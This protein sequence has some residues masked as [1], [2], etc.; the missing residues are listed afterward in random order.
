MHVMSFLE[1]KRGRTIDFSSDGFIRDSLEIISRSPAE[2]RAGR[3]DQS[4][5]PRPSR[6][7]LAEEPRLSPP[8]YNAVINLNKHLKVNKR[9]LDRHILAIDIVDMDGKVISSTNETMIGKDVSGQDIY[10][11]GISRNYG[12]TYV[13]QSHKSSYMDANCIFISA[14]LTSK[15]VGETI[16]VIINAYALASLND[17]TANRVGMGE[18]GEVYIVNNRDKTMLTESR[19]IEDVVLKMVVDTEPVRRIS[20]GGKGMTAIY[21]N[22][23][24]VPIVGASVVIPEYDWI[25]LAEIDKAEAF[26]PLRMLGIVALVLG[27]VCAAVTISLGIVFSLSTARPINRLK[28]ASERIAS[29]NLKHRVDITRKDEIGDLASSFNNMAHKLENEILEHKRAEDELSATNK[30]LEAFCYSV[31]HDLRAPLRGIDGFSKALVEDFAD[32]LDSEGKGYLH[33]IRTAC[34]RMGQLIDDLLALSRI[35]RRDMRRERVDL[36]AIAQEIVMDLQKRRPGRQVEFVITE[37]LEA[38]GDIQLVQLALLNLLDNAWKFTGKRPRAKIE[39]GVTQNGDGPVYFVR[40]DGAGFDMEYV[41]KLFVAFQ[42]LHDINEFE[43]TG[44]GLAIVQRVIHR[45]GG[46]IWAEGRVEQG[47]TFYFT[48]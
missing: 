4:S 26:A 12:E 15:R 34:Q 18:T 48:L 24:G 8:R 29:G 11:K 1:A 40:D 30:E 22:Y 19:F 14:P 45:H 3:G 7:R 9:L 25:L 35:T 33:R 23:R 27:G 17:I 43:G 6:L 42:R 31:S 36:S 44:V 47:A 32:R 2:R 38:N 46:R 37:G 10:I 16:G 13:D 28:Y 41:D 5:V 39:F 21:S 20:E